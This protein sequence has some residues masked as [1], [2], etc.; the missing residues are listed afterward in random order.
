[1]ID[2]D[3]KNPREIQDKRIVGENEFSESED[4]G[5]NNT[6]P[7]RDNRLLFM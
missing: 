1:M 2:P 5:C 4:E 6:A 3:V 7:R